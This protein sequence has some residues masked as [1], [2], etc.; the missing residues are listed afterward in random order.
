MDSS[1]LWVTQGIWMISQNSVPSSPS[2]GPWWSCLS[3]VPMGKAQPCPL[4]GPGTR[5]HA[6]TVTKKAVSASWGAT[7]CT[8]VPQGLLPQG[9]GDCRV[10]SLRS[11][12][13]QGRCQ[14]RGSPSLKKPPSATSEC[15]KQLSTDGRAEEEE[16]GGIPGFL[17]MGGTLTREK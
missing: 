6:G 12:T 3:S 1:L 4:H 8:Q 13:S 9:Q 10:P 14:L 17:C 5:G 16:Q 2:P 7:G 11:C 15:A